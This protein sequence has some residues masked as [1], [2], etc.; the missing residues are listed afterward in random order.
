MCW[1]GFAISELEGVGALVFSTT[2]TTQQPQH[3]Y[4]FAAPTMGLYD[5]SPGICDVFDAE[6]SGMV[7]KTL[8]EYIPS[9]R[10]QF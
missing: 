10:Q 8:K 5:W 2:S 1:R 9:G 3:I 4:C 7:E 6:L